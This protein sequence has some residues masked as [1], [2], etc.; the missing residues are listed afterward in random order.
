MIKVRAHTCYLGHTG[1]AAHARNFFRELSKHV[2]LRVRNYTWDS[3]PLLDEIDYSIL[4]KITLSN[5]DNTQSDYPIS[6]SFPNLPWLNK[7]GFQQDVDI[8]LMDMHHTYFYQEYTAPIKIAYTVWESTELEKGFF[9]QLLKFDYL[10]V[11]TQ[12]HKD[13]IIK[14][15]YPADKIFIVN[16]GVNSIFFEHIESDNDKFKFMF[17]GRWD[18][19]KAVPEIIDTFLKSFPNNDNVELILSADNPY[20]VD[21]FTSTEE[22]LKNY[23]FNDDRIKVLHF[24]KYEEYVNYIKTGN[25]LITCARSEGWNIPL[26][27][28][29]AAGTPTTYSNWGAQLEFAKGLGNPVSIRTELSANI[30]KDLGFAGDTPGLYA[31]PDYNDLQRVLIDCYENYQIKKESA[32]KDSQIIKEKFN[33]EKI[34]I[35][36]YNTLKKIVDMKKNFEV[37]KKDAVVVMSHA[38]DSDKLNLLEKCILANK[39]NG[40]TVILSSHIDVPQHIC[41]LVDYIIID[42]DNPIITLKESNEY[43]NDSIF[44]FWSFKD[45]DIKQSFK[46]NHSYAAL[47]LIKNGGVLAELNGF[48]K[49]HFV[50]YDYVIVDNTLEN[51]SLLLN[52]NDI[53]SY[54]WNTYNDKLA[55]NTGFFSTNISIFNN[56]VKDLNS[57]RNYFKYPGSVTLE[58]V[59]GSAILEHNIKY[60]LIDIESVKENNII[61]A[62][63]IEIRWTYSSGCMVAKHDNNYYII[64]MQNN[65]E[66]YHLTINEKEYNVVANTYCKFIKVNKSDLIK[67]ISVNSDI[68]TIDDV[69]AS[70]VIKTPGILDDIDF[71]DKKEDKIIINYLDGP[72]V[73]ILG[74]SDYRYHVKFIDSN[75][76]K[77]L[78]DCVISPNQWTRCSIKYFVN[79]KIQIENLSTKQITIDKFNLDNKIIRV[80]L[81]SSSLGDTLAWTP[82][83]NEFAEKN[84]CIVI[85]STFKNFLFETEKYP[86][87]RFVNPGVTYENTYCNYMIGWFYDNN[88]VNFYKNPR[89]FKNIPLQA[90]TSDILGL[91]E[92]SVKPFIKVNNTNS[93]L[94]TKYICIAIHSTAQAKYWNNP[95]G[96]QEIT[97][98]Y[99]SKGF[100]VVVVSSEHDGYMGNKNPE[101]VLYMKDNSMDTLITYLYN[102]EMFIGISSGISWLSWAL[103]KKTVIISGFSKPITEPLDDNVIR[104]FN[105]SV[106]N[107]CFNSHKLDAGDWNWCP[108][109]K[110]TDKQ[111]E[112]SKS[113]TSKQ[114]I[115]IIESG[116]TPQYRNNNEIEFIP[117]NRDFPILAEQPHPSAWGNI[118][119][120][121]KDIIERFDVDTTNALEFGVEYGYSTSALSNYFSNVLGV[122]IFTGDI[123]SGLKD[124]HLEQT[125][126]YLEPY[127]NITLLK[128]DYKDFIKNNFGKYG[129]THIDI[130]HDFEHTYECGAW[131][132]QHSRVTIFHDTESYA[133][134]KRACQELSYNYDLEFYN[135]KESHGLGI[136]VNR[137]IK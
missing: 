43:T 31:E 71:I 67:G 8:V 17:F 30:G 99:K 123:H 134:V 54:N 101:G 10:W 38:D 58:N 96:W 110:G 126:N 2:D 81:D 21:G 25:V 133:E 92:S 12:W 93:P 119:T 19:R 11:V 48:E 55:V 5:S 109:N 50:N 125:K 72:F 29:M 28:A 73:E 32:L 89:D 75:N 88:K 49:V 45:F 7:Q 83:V 114:V 108:I 52:S 124:D 111:F 77:I 112:C 61:N 35:D 56:I 24:P 44:S 137:K 127:K 79:W 132:V 70:I 42:R 82:H 116:K 90:T 115:S 47:K 80:S 59:I 57:K 41:D 136:L 128:S 84:N 76:D 78:Y 94:D 14:Q 135:Y 74:D 3:N 103:N 106:C 15:G 33:W 121:L 60:H 6:Y 34:G 16:E 22:R 39:R 18:Y 120:I 118:P 13:M 95:T 51:N 68:F 122:D 97:N 1:F 117:K 4:D 26:I 37:N 131:A 23:N 91:K 40:Y 129:L 20:S 62:I 105:E 66:K 9:N 130:I 100:E 69:N 98:H 104:I 27:E 65:N 85:V 107:G 53:I 46:F 86:R 63:K 64:F 36:G 87:L 102:C 113:I